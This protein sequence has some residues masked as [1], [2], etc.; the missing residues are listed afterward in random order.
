LVVEKQIPS[1]RNDS[2]KGRS[3]GKSNG[4]SKATARKRSEFGERMN[5]SLLLRVMSKQQAV[6]GWKRKWC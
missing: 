4:K 3:N 5:D 1:L 2:Q 6:F